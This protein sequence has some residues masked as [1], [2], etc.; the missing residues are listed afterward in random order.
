MTP[1]TLRQRIHGII[2]FIPLMWSWSRP[3]QSWCC[4]HRREGFEFV[5]WPKPL[6]MRLRAA[7]TMWHAGQWYEWPEHPAP[8]TAGGEA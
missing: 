4:F 2:V 8:S 3:H 7:F 5:S 6:W 1:T